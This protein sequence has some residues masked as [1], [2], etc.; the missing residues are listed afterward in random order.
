M[1]TRVT[2]LCVPATAALRAGRFP[3]DEPLA[4]RDITS[5]GGVAAR[6]ADDGVDGVVHSP[7]QSARDTAGAL[8]WPASVEPDLREIDYGRWAGQSLKDIA[9]S[10]PDD[11]AAWLADPACDAHGGES[12]HAAL[13]R[14]GRWM[15]RFAWAPGHTLVIT[16]AT[17]IRAAVAHALQVDAHAGQRI[18]IAPLSLT[19]LTGGAGQ[20]RLASLG[21]A[22]A[23]D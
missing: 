20:W 18:D 7:M 17:V 5:V 14:V 21:V 8:P 11:L 10:W 1:K 9:A 13:A 22:A 15:D 23:S 2:L 12:Q 4:P 16:H 19:T 3:L 6:M